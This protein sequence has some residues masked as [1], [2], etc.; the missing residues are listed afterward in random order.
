[1]TNGGGSD[2]ATRRVLLVGA[3][4]CAAA[5]ET[6]LEDDGIDVVS[7]ASA[8]VALATLDSVD[9]DCAVLVDSVGGRPEDFFGAAHRKGHQ[10]P[11]VYVGSETRP[12]PASVEQAPADPD[13]AAGVIRQRLLVGAAADAEPAVTDDPLA[14]YG[15]TVAHELRNHLGAAG[16]AVESMEGPTKEQATAALERLRDLATEAEAVATGTVSDAEVVDLATVVGAAAD[17]IHVDGFSVEADADSSLEAN[18]A[19]LV[20]LFE[21]LF[22]NSVEHAG[23]DTTVRTLDTEVGFAVVDDGPGFESDRPFEW[24]YTTGSGQGAGLAVV[25]RIV[26]AHGWHVTASNDGGAR[27]DVVTE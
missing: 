4:D 9:V 24:G 25:R 5:L 20:L 10:L 23:A 15:S 2:I 11:G 7:V 8:P 27:V 26:Q 19:L 21:N 14:A 1:M 16:L 22:R 3:D 12:L 17:R 13:A 18:R 6:T